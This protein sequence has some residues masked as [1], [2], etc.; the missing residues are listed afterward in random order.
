MT[1]I[2]RENYRIG[3][4]EAGKLK[5]VFN[6]DLKKYNGTGTFKNKAFETEKLEWQFRK[7]SAQ[8]IVPP[9]GM[10]VFKYSK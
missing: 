1:P 10:V 8:I 4:P 2:P 9:L 3:L 6:S 7:H 5:E